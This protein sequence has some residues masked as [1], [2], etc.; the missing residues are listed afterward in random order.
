MES[1]KAK[2]EIILLKIAELSKVIDGLV[3]K[4]NLL[5]KECS[6]ILNENKY[7][8]TILEKNVVEYYYL[9]NLDWNEVKNIMKISKNRTDYGA[10]FYAN[11]LAGRVLFA[12]G[13]NPYSAGIFENI[14]LRHTHDV[15]GRLLFLFYQ[16]PCTTE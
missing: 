15:Q 9:D 5:Y 4:Y 14:V 7:K 8:F 2:Q 1:K 16:Y 11:W 10:S 12:Q 6:E 13:Q 3:A